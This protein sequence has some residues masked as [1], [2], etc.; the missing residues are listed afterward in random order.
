MSLTYTKKIQ[1][2]F[3]K[4]DELIL[5]G[6]SKICN[7]LYNQLLDACQKDYY[8]NNNSLKLLEGRNLRNYGVSLKKSHPFLNSVFSSVL[9]EPSTRL[10]RAYKSFFK[11]NTRYPIHRS[12]KKKWFS[13]V[14]DEPN[15]GWEIQKEGK[16]VSISLGKVPGLPKQK[17]KKNPSIIGKLKE[18]VELGDGENLKTFSLCKQQG[19]KFFAIFTI[20]RCS[21]T[22]IEFKKAMSN[23]RV[24][25]FKSKKLNEPLPQK[26]LLIKQELHIPDNIKWISLDP[27]HKNFFVGVDDEGNSIEFKK[28]L[29]INYWD[30]KI[31][32]LKAKRDICVK[33]CKTKKSKYGNSYTIH[34]PRWNKLN[35]A[36]NRAYNKRREQIKT[37]LYSIAHA[38]YDRYDLVIIGDYTPANKHAPFKNMKRSM[39]NQEQIGKFRS[40]LKWVATKRGKYFLLSDEYNTTKEC[41]VC[42]YMR[43]RD[44]HI[45]SFT[46]EN[47]GTPLMRDINSSVNIGKKVGYKLNIPLYKHKLQSF[48]FFGK[49]PY[50]TEISWV[51]N[52]LYCL[53]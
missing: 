31:D 28:L 47:C 20:E 35:S 12:W 44:P 16:A 2:E 40:I 36:V 52:N 11:G 43:K 39:L 50:G 17:G 24:H 18:K 37:A 34:S 53:A 29:M 19:D 4:K 7:W 1:I 49:A 5:D 32:Q 3:S 23:Y 26:P 13:L 21:K 9:K 51:K 25:C 41:C 48:T 46:C 15:K 38:L 27:N 42:G 8:E 30:K 22:E 6:Q 45:R 14:F 33:Q 10:L